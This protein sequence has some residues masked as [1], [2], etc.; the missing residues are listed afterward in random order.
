MSIEHGSEDLV[1]TQ[2]RTKIVRDEG[3]GVALATR[4]PWLQHRRKPP[5]RHCQQ[6][7]LRGSGFAVL[8]QSV[9]R[10][11]VPSMALLLSRQ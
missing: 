7:R 8:L 5:S 1:T 4:K 6:R 10:D 9:G 3:C 2:E 11:D